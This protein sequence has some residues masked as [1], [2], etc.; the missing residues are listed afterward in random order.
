METPLYESG[1]L[2]EVTCLSEE[3]YSRLACGYLG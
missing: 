3:D 2:G 1:I